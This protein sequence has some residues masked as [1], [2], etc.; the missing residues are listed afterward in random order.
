MPDL[1][2]NRNGSD[3]TIAAA[4]AGKTAGG[5][6]CLAARGKPIIIPRRAINAKPVP[7]A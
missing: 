5:P 7:I 3:N 6:K 2:P 1:S 4:S